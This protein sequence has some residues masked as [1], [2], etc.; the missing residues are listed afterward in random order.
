MDGGTLVNTRGG[1]VHFTGISWAGGIGEPA[2]QAEPRE[3]GF[4]SGACLAVTRAEW[5]RNP[6]FPRD[7]FLYFDDVDY[8]LRVRLGG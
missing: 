8:S 2:G 6:G 4:A 1:E 7:Y 5:R 3:V